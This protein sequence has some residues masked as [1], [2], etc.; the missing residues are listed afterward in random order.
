MKLL[1]RVKWDKVLILALTIAVFSF[2]I[3]LLN[4]INDTKIKLDDRTDEV[5]ALKVERDNLERVISNQE[6]ELFQL[7]WNLSTAEDTIKELKGK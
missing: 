6:S 2:V 4:V 3:F 5:Q 1:K 7:R